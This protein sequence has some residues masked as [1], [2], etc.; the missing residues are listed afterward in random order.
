M[1]VIRTFFDRNEI[2]F[3]D[4]GTTQ[5]RGKSMI[6]LF[7]DAFADIDY[8]IKSFFSPTILD[9][10]V[11]DKSTHELSFSSNKPNPRTI[12]CHVFDSWPEVG[13]ENY[14]K[15]CESIYLKGKLEPKYN[16]LFWIGNVET[17]LSRKKLLSKF[18]THPEMLLIDSGQWVTSEPTTTKQHISLD[19]HCEYRFL[20]DVRGNGYSGR[21][22]IL[23][24]SGR[25]VFYQNRN[26]HEYWFW[27]TTP[28]I[29]YIPVAEDF[30]DLGEKLD[31]AKKN[32]D[33]CKNIAFNAQNFHKQHLMRKNAVDRCKDIL[34]HHGIDNAQGN[35]D[36][37]FNKFKHKLTIKLG[38]I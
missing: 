4:L 29:H 22:K 17:H 15:T 11:N 13:I 21:T 32:P 6:N 26:C 14:D 25:P 28:F 38:L 19:D 37:I 10:F 16:K 30:S 8:G 12:P 36:L 24:N 33:A 2:T 1:E 35:K 23:L 7:S 27:Q 9:V 34:I 3:A 31:W 18:A 20:L 5:T